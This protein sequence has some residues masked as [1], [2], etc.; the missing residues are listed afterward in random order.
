M[1]L[2][3]VL[4]DFRLLNDPALIKVCNNI[5]ITKLQHLNI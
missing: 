5:S 4:I 1:F 3:I 2:L